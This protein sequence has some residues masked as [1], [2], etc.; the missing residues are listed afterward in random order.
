MIRLHNACR[1]PRRRPAVIQALTDR[2]D[3]RH[4]PAVNAMRKELVA[5][6]AWRVAAS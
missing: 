1:Q 6:P 5:D 2:G 3:W 4:H